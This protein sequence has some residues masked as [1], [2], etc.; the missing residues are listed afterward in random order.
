ML[1]DLLYIW[2]I[3]SAVS[4]PLSAAVALVCL[5]EMDRQSLTY[6]TVLDELLGSVRTIEPPIDIV[7]KA[8][9]GAKVFA[10]LIIS[11]V[12]GKRV[13][14]G[15]VSKQ[16]GNSGGNNGGNNGTNNGTNN[17]GKKSDK[18]ADITGFLLSNSPSA[19][20]RN[21][22]NSINLRFETIFKEAAFRHWIELKVRVTE[23]EVPKEYE[24]GEVWVGKKYGYRYYE[25]HGLTRYREERLKNPYSPSKDVSSASSTGSSPSTNTQSS[26][27]A[28]MDDASTGTAN[29]ASEIII[30]RP[31]DHVSA[32]VGI[33]VPAERSGTL[34]GIPAPLPIY[35]TFAYTLMRGPVNGFGIG[36][37]HGNNIECCILGGPDVSRQLSQA[38]RDH[39]FK[40][41]SGLQKGEFPYGTKIC[42][43]REKP[44]RLSLNV[45]ILGDGQNQRNAIS[46]Y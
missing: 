16:H 2:L 42:L 35:I 4:T 43:R 18:K 40:P 32:C 33:G 44:S 31:P 37:I 24:I 3:E 7:H 8:K 20:S 41:L 22:D 26:N 30:S 12:D 19:S 14:G 27:F 34:P 46:A 5:A 11:R 15:E 25:S 13:D 29:T 28:A 36:Y 1:A 21:S 39:Q 9:E 17:G 45:Q 6:T 10:E 23:S 38:I